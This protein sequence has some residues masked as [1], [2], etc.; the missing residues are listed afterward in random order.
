MPIYEYKC[1]CPELTEVLQKY[2]DEPLDVCPK[3]EGKMTKVIG[4]TGFSLVGS[5]WAR[6][7]YSG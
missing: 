7:G 4:K 2:S 5:C 6:D 1:D 3:C